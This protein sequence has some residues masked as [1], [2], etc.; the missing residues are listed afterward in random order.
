MTKP[1]KIL[2]ADDHEVV[3]EGVRTI[4]ESQA[5]WSIVGEAQN[6]ADAVSKALETKPDIALLDISMPE[7]NGLE[8]A[9][10]ILKGLPDTQV[11]ILTMHESDELVRELLAAGARGYILKTDARRDLV[12]AI[13]FLSEGRPF[14][15]SKVAEMVLNGFRQGR[16]PAKAEIS[17]GDRLTARERQIVQLLAEGKTS[18]E[19]ATALDISVKTADTHRANLMRKLNLHSLADIVRYAIRNKMI[20]P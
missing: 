16:A 3:R 12:N 17:V 15:T 5:G 7:L 8:A 20:E 18:K 1:L 13:C 11:L 9:R 6:G 14:F 2:I 19:I 10:Q 4:L